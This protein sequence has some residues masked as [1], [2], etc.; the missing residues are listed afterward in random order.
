VATPQ[1]LAAVRYVVAAAAV[2]LSIPTS[3]LSQSLL[4]ERLPLTVSPRL[5]L[6]SELLKCLARGKSEQV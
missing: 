3:L 2:A 6:G 4:L 5:A 1:R